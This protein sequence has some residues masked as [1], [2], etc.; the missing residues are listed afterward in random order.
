MTVVEI[1]KKREAEDRANL[2]KLLQMS[3]EEL[4]VKIFEGAYEYLEH[5]FGTDAYGMDH[6]PKT[7]QFW[8][9]WRREWAKIDAVFLHAVEV[10]PERFRYPGT[11]WAVRDRDN[12]ECRCIVR[13][14][15]ALR[16]QYEYYH[17]A[18]MSNRYLNSEIVR[19]GM[20]QMFK[21]MVAKQEEVHRG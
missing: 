19:A 10:S 18:S 5:V 11:L 13:E 4:N 16:E 21:D 17:E 20:H 6:L 7:P 12:T 3:E 1:L 15:H 8:T 2:L 14:L 9:W